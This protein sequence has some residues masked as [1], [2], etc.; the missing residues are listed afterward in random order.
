MRCKT[1]E[2]PLWTIRSRVCPECGS[3]FA[4]SDYEFNLNS[5]RFCCPHCDQQY[6]G[7][8]P[9]GH[10]EPRSFECRKCHR[11]IDMDEMV[12][13]PR[14]GIDEKMTEVRRLPWGNEERSFFSRF[15]GQVGWGMTRPQEVGRGITEQTSASSA[16]GFGLLINIVSLV[17]GVGA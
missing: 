7:T 17:F 15:F 1:C 13:L 16:L 14:E 3:S 2:Y 6:F 9:N 8:A 4:P 10:L 12:L 11:F 5:V